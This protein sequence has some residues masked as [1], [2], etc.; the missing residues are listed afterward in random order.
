MPTMVQP[1][2]P[3]ATVSDEVDG[4]RI[5]IPPRRSGL[6]F[7]LFWLAFWSYAGIQ[8]GQALMRHFSY[9]LAFW[10]LGWVY[11][12]LFASY[13]I[14]YG[15]GGQEIIVA[16]SETLTRTTKIFGLGWSKAY[17]VRE[18]GNLRFQRGAN[19][20]P[21]RIAFD[22]GARTITFGAYIDEAEACELMRKIRQRCAIPDSSA[23]PAPGIKFW[24]G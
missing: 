16:N 21:S 19:R 8:S 11:G 10:M 4:L 22:Y 9:F 1:F 7:I 2:G 17:L 3:R 12:E 15:L 6:L 24:Q 14:L 5:S 20:Q 13:S 18:M 23:T